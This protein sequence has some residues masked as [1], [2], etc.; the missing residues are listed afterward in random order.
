MNQL[1]WIPSF[2]RCSS[3]HSMKSPA[4]FLAGALTLLTQFANAQPCNFTYTSLNTCTYKF[5]SNVNEV[6]GYLIKHFWDF[7]DGSTSDVA[8]PTHSYPS[9]GPGGD[10]AIYTVIHIV[11]ICDPFTLLPV[12]T[13]TC[14]D[15]IDFEE[16]GIPECNLCP[17]LVESGPIFDYHV[18]GCTVN[19]QA[20]IPLGFTAIWNFGD[21]TLPTVQSQNFTYTYSHS[22]VYTVSVSTINTA[23]PAQ[24][25]R[26]QR[27]ITVD[28][29]RPCCDFAWTLD[30]G[31]CFDLKMDVSSCD[32]PGASYVWYVDGQFAGNGPTPPNLFPHGINICE[33]Q[34]NGGIVNV[35][36]V[37]QKDGESCIV[38][39]A[40][41]FNSIQDPAIYIGSGPLSSYE[42]VLPGNSYCGP[43]DVRVCGMV[44]VDKDFEFCA[45]N[46]LV[47]RGMKGFNVLPGNTFSLA[48]STHMQGC[49]CI[50][51]G[52]QAQSGATVN[53][54]QN[55][56]IEDAGY[57][58]W[59][60]AGSTVHLDNANFFNNYVG[61][62]M[63]GAV[64]LGTF[65]S[66]HF[67]TTR[68]LL[69]DCD[70]I[71]SGLGYVTSIGYAG[72]QMDHDGTNL[73]I[74]GNANQNIFDNLAVGMYSTDGTLTL[75]SCC[76]FQNMTNCTD[77]PT[78]TAQASGSRGIWFVNDASFTS[79]GN[80]FNDVKTGILGTTTI[81]TIVD[82]NNNNMPAIARGIDLRTR[83]GGRMTGTI[84]NNPVNV[85]RNPC[86]VAPPGF[87]YGIGFED[88]TTQVNDI[89]IRDNP[90]TV[91]YGGG[92][93][94]FSAYGIL[95]NQISTANNAQVQVDVTDNPIS[96]TNGFAGIWV[97]NF[98]RAAV[99]DN[100]ITGNPT[101]G[102]HLNAGTNN[103]VC[104]NNITGGG[105]GLRIIGSS[106]ATIQS[107]TMTN[108]GIG[109]YFG[110]DCGFDAS[111]GCNTFS[112]AQGFGLF[113]EANAKVGLQ[114]D[115]EVNTG[116]QWD[117]TFSGTRAWINLLS[118]IPNNMF[119]VPEGHPTLDPGNTQSFLGQD[120]FVS[121]WWIP[122]GNCAVNTCAGFERPA[123]KRSEIEKTAPTQTSAPLALQIAPNPNAGDFTVTFDKNPDDTAELQVISVSGAVVKS[124]QVQP[125]ESMYRISGMAPGI[126]F[127]K[128][129]S[130][131][132]TSTPVKM[133]VF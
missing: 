92:L 85:N 112:G 122:E 21:G 15:V 59:G 46:I 24:T 5:T 118:N 109:A 116:N 94:G 1:N 102:I 32:L 68:T 64:N 113:Y 44:D 70:N 133:V 124:Y 87:A 100:Q 72:M 2:G 51:R 10:P 106:A 129:T 126:Y 28:C 14:H 89:M 22:G 34:Q 61:V 74:S 103:F 69:S 39:K 79:T 107:N 56:T 81:P 120:W 54:L 93:P 101:F 45:A 23:N 52:I 30:A 29:D 75:Q 125:G 53:V 96:V 67:S 31:C 17:T 110:G 128:M 43:C 65:L 123:G 20:H 83:T 7:G 99:Y 35:S 60:L 77:Y 105:T 16:P 40:V 57:A 78:A 48:K 114:A 119:F 115:W 132:K 12:N 131:G 50:Y 42:N 19:F 91:S 121:E 98:I 88:N 108:T 62:R 111:F 18:T 11:T 58:V 73:T 38:T 104:S 33:I 63:D 97:D 90:I 27:I 41:D 13:F 6:D 82:I 127:V 25:Y 117:I 47:D 84:N 3:K 66:N 95:L 130:N 76:T 26:C 36:L 49:D 9:S 80:I 86:I 55:S 71:L 4:L 37:T 8:N